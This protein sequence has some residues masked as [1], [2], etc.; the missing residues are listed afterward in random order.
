MLKQRIGLIGAGR[1]ATA[2]AKGVLAAGL[3]APEN[4]LAADPS[5]EA[6]QRFAAATGG[7]GVEDNR[8]VVRWA[9]V[10]VLAVKPQSLT[11]ASAGLADELSDEH[12]VI[13][14][15]AGTQLAT[16][17]DVLGPRARLIRVMPNTPCLIGCGASGFCVGRGATTGDRELVERLL[18]AVGLAVEVDEPLLD[19]VTGLSGSGPAFVY[20]MIE[21]LI[22]SGI[23]LGLTA[24]VAQCL[25][26]ETVRG[27]AEMVAA[28][29]EQPRVLRDQVTSPGGTTA[30]GLEVLRSRGFREAVADAV[31]AAA[32][33]SAE[34]GAT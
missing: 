13:S 6:R 14:I 7:R 22:D 8:E 20:L 12:L 33:R 5:A 30:A 31:E 26:V 2:L 17:D 24:D 25:A 21:S 23:R 27:A 10:V 34:L 19:V 9:D 28:T 11:A 4:L 15:L 3:T 1:M 29:G 18:G 16:L 32:R